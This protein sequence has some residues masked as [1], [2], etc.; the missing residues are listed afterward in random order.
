MFEI[1]YLFSTLFTNVVY[2]SPISYIVYI[3]YIIVYM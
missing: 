2:H 1:F 3:M